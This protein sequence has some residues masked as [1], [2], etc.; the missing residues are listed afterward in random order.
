MK[1]YFLR[2][3]LKVA[4]MIVEKYWFSQFGKNLTKFMTVSKLQNN[5]CKPNLL[6]KYNGEQF[7]YI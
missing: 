2:Y 1:H 6:A 5:R 3:I 4:K 7:I